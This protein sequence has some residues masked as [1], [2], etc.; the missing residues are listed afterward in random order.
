MKKLFVLMLIFFFSSLLLGQVFPEEAIPVIESK[1][2]L[3][4]VDESP[5]TFSEFRTAVEK[6]FPGKG[7]LIEGTGEVSRANFAVA[8]VEVLDLKSEADAYDEICTTALD[9]WDAPKEAWGALTVAYRSN[10]QLLD[11]RY[12]HAIEADSP[13]TRKEA[14]ISIYMALNPPVA[15]GI[16]T[17]AVTA[18]APGFN[19]LFTSAMLAFLSRDGSFSIQFFC[20]CS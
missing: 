10:Y 20:A 7:E 19:T 16:A 2:I 14:A 8:M 3:F 17:T 11:F 9:E 6:A 5:L 4:S 1:G 18:D 15:G 12:G 13:I